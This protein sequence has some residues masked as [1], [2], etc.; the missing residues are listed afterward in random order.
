MPNK[1]K[2][3]RGSGVGNKAK[4]AAAKPKRAK[5]SGSRVGTCIVTTPM[6]TKVSGT[7]YTKEGCD[8]W[9]TSMKGKGEWIP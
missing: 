3:G 2:S 4:Q 6:G 7:G 1:G 9:A 5:S 8:E